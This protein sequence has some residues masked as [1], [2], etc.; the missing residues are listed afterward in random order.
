MFRPNFFQPD[1]FPD[2]NFILFNIGKVNSRCAL[3]S[4]KTLNDFI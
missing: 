3:V 4:E 2:I 1:T